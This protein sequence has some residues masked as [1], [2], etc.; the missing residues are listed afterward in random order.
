MSSNLNKQLEQMD[1]IRISISNLK[2]DIVLLKEKHDNKILF[3]NEIKKDYLS[4]VK[5][6]LLDKTLH[7]TIRFNVWFNYKEKDSIDGLPKEGSLLNALLKCDLKKN[8]T[9]KIFDILNI[10]PSQIQTYLSQ[11]KDYYEKLFEDIIKHNIITFY[12]E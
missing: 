6:I 9:Y 3:L 12:N 1:N 11:D 4:E 2:N 5:N 7:I 10:N 8:H